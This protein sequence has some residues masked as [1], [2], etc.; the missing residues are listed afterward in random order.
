MPRITIANIPLPP[1]LFLGL[2]SAT[3]FH[4]AGFLL[5]FLLL[6]ALILPHPARGRHMAVVVRVMTRAVRVTVTTT[7]GRGRQERRFVARSV[8]VRPAL[9]PTALVAV[10]VTIVMT[11]MVATTAMTETSGVAEEGRR[12]MA[13]SASVPVAGV[14]ET[15]A[16]RSIDGVG[17]RRAGGVV[18]ENVDGVPQANQAPADGNGTRPD[19][20]AAMIIR[21]A[22]AAEAKA[23]T[24]D[25]PCC[26]E[27]RSGVGSAAL[28]RSGRGLGKCARPRAIP[29]IPVGVVEDA[30]LRGNKILPN[31]INRSRKERQDD[32]Q[33]AVG[34][35]VNL[36]V[37]A[38]AAVGVSNHA[39]GPEN[40]NDNANDAVDISGGTVVSQLTRDIMPL[41]VAPIHTTGTV[42]SNARMRGTTNKRQTRNTS[43]GVRCST[44][45]LPFLAP[46]PSGRRRS[47]VHRDNRALP[48]TTAAVSIRGASPG[49]RLAR[50]V[51][52]VAPPPRRANSSVSEAPTATAEE[53]LGATVYLQRAS[54]EAG[55][56]GRTVRRRP[57]ATS[58]V[59]PKPP[60]NNP[61]TARPAGLSGRQHLRGAVRLERSA[62][63]R[64]WL[65]V[66]L[67]STIG[68]T[69]IAREADVDPTRR[70]NQSVSRAPT[71]AAGEGL[72]T[73]V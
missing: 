21:W 27:D 11:I 29:V 49:G 70:A 3:P 61:P 50:A 69:D 68:R 41:I 12:P 64:S 73:V 45:V 65:C 2:F 30:K 14:A 26:K 60:N 57:S 72:G 6:L 51:A 46:G 38:R 31:G 17:R 24:A 62:T 22:L 18:V 66:R 53:G 67:S 32:F 20:H 47:L 35:D 43:R 63:S 42:K 5:P 4:P 55:A 48:D 8:S 54:S 52:E 56:I 10:E 19:H 1:T 7:S 40:G 36:R 59:V 58:P 37:V 71:A 28:A 33:S 15:T 25:P 9:T 34:N 16:T 39:T 13:A 23:S 44:F